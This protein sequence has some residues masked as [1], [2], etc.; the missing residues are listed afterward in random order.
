MST[1]C[2]R[3]YHKSPG[4]QEWKRKESQQSHFFPPAHMLWHE[5]LPVGRDT[6]MPQIP[7]MGEL[8]RLAQ[9]SAGQKLIAFLQSNG[10]SGLQKAI[11][12][13]AAGDYTRAKEILSALLSAPEAQTLLKE[14][15][16]QK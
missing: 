9:T 15:E 10:G 4:C 16:G 7:D 12:S 5:T 8:L 6:D 11:A 14:L 13:A 2:I 3:L 1:V